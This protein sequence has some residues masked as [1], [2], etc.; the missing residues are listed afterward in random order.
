MVQRPDLNCFRIVTVRENVPAIAASASTVAAPSAPAAPTVAAAPLRVTAAGRVQLVGLDEVRESLGDRWPALKER[1]MATAE[2]VL[3]RR[4]GSRDTFSQTDDNGFVVAFAGISEQEASFRAAAIGNE[5]RQ[6]LIGTGESPDA[7]QVLAVAVAVA[8]EDQG[9][10]SAEFASIVKD[11]VSQRLRAIQVSARETLAVTLRT[12]PYEIEPVYSARDPAKP[13]GRY[14]RFTTEMRRT[15]DVALGALPAAESASLDPDVMMVGFAHECV[16]EH[17]LPS[18]GSLVFVPLSSEILV[19]RKRMEAC[20]EAYRAI[21]EP[22]RKHLVLVVTSPAE[23][24]LRKI[25]AG[26]PRLRSFCKGLGVAVERYDRAELDVAGAGIQ[27]VVVDGS[28]PVLPATFKASADSLRALRCHL[29]VHGAASA[30][31]KRYFENGAA[32]VSIANGVG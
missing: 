13:I 23:G 9:R 31:S 18:P 12:N 2:I 16:I 3:R 26:L 32:F 25:S 1:A 24:A 19:A 14:L 29:L 27:F 21:D 28:T 5:I 10:S 20:I 22:L 7:S 6:R 30:D 11:R 4:L 17:A 15:L 8:P